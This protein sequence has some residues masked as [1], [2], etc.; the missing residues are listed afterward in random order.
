MRRAATGPGHNQFQET[1]ELNRNLLRQQWFRFRLFPW[2]AVAVS[3]RDPNGS[4]LIRHLRESRGGRGWPRLPGLWRRLEPRLAWLLACQ[5]SWPPRCKS[6]FLRGEFFAELPRP[7][8][9][10]QLLWC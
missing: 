2:Q 5:F 8:V 6:V 7:A 1:V 10:M 3:V 4:H 9:E